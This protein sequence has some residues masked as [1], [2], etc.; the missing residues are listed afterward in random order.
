MNSSK[1]K[2]VI[3]LNNLNETL[4]SI[5]FQKVMKRQRDH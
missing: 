1:K 2:F 4:L 3:Y 5:F